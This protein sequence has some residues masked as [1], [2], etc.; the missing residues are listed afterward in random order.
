MR[1]GDYKNDVLFLLFM[2]YLLMVCQTCNQCT[3]ND[4]VESE[5]RS[6]KY[7]IR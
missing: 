2:I 5:I 7:S 6:L 4:R 1:N 3:H